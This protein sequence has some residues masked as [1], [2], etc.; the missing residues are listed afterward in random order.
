MSAVASEGAGQWQERGHAA[1]YLLKRSVHCDCCGRMLISRAWVS[2]GHVFCEPECE[3][4]YR[5]YWIPRY[6][7]PER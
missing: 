2:D 1:D 3:R 6:G 4:L 7:E 5:D